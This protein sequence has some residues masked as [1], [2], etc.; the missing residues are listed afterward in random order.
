MES[1]APP[2]QNLKKQLGNYHA[3]AVDKIREHIPKKGPRASLYD[4]VLDYPTRGGKGFRP[5]LCMATCNAFGGNN[6]LALNTAAALELFHNAFLVHDD[7]EDESHLR[8]GQ[9][10]MHEKEGLAIAVNVGDAMNVLGMRPL[11]ANIS[12]LGH[13]MTWEIFTEVEHMVRQSVEGQ[14]M[15]LAWVRANESFISEEDYLEMVLKKTCWYTTIHPMRLGAMIANAEVASDE[16]NL[17]GYYMG[18]AFQ[19]Q[20]DVLNLIADEKKYGKET[21]GDIL[22]GKRTLMLIHLMNQCTKKERAALREFLGTSRSS[23]KA[24]DIKWVMLLMQ[25]YGSID[26]GIVS[27]KQLAGAALHEFTRIFSSL[28]ASPDKELL[29]D[30]VLYMIHRDY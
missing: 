24:C 26:H 4:L 29:E 19:I 11:M 5:G 1:Q 16:F 12:S 21:G 22:E 13:E 14:A 23:G 15:E 9:P 7:I 27:S 28:P 8:R 3:R 20:D 25:K 10:T 18:A 30:L 6:D 17:F 2:Y